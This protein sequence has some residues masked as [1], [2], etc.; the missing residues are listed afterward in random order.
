MVNYAPL[1]LF[2]GNA[3]SSLSQREW[4]QRSTLDSTMSRLVIT[5]ELQLVKTYLLACVP[6]EDSN[7]PVHLRSLISMRCPRK[8]TLHSWL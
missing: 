4:K 8:E 6:N 7:Q 5:F 1:I 2:V 3:L